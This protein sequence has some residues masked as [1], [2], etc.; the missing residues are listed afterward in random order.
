MKVVL[1]CGG[2]GTR[3]REFSETIPKPLVPVGER[4][5]LWHLMRYYAHHGHDEFVLCLGYKGQMIKE[6][7]L[8]YDDCLSN[9]FTICKDSNERI[10][11]GEDTRHWRISFLD[12]GL[13]SNIGQRLLQVREWVENEPMFLANY[14]DGLCDLP[15]DR[16]IEEFRRSNA[17]A[18]FVAVR[19]SNSLS[20]IDADDDGYVRRIDYL[21]RTTL[22]NGGFFI[23]RPEIFDYIQEGEEMVE[24]PFGRLIAER[25]LHC[26]RYDG[27]WRAMDTFKDKK[28]FDTLHESGERPWE[29]WR[30]AR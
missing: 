10:L 11:H 21:S 8:N 19:P 5:I 25:K 22:I 1:F 14:S 2:Y 27:F 18:S 23:I 29:V 26:L 7:F 28:E 13:A 6:F 4:P 15:L 20:G 24:E 17:V 9:D 12:T 30:R 16:H 3:M